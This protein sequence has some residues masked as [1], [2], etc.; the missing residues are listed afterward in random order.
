MGVLLLLGASPAWAVDLLNATLL[1]P[2]TTRTLILPPAADNAN[3]IPLGTAVDPATGEIVEGLAIIHYKKAPTHR[4][5]HG[6][7]G[8]TACYTYLSN[9]AKWKNVEPWVVN[10]ANLDDLSSTAVFDLLTS[11]IAKWED[12]TDGNV[13]N[14]LGVDVLGTGATSS[15]PLVADTTSP[16]NQNEVYFADIANS[17]TIAVTIVWGIF[18]GPTFNRKLVEWDQ[19]YD[20]VTFDWSAQSSG[21]LGKMDLDNIITHELGH[22]FGMGDLYNSCVDETMYGFSATAETNKRDLNTGDITGINKLY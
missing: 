2:G 4:P 8:T 19:I 3:V 1:T 15:A 17:N 11:G 16:D 13:G 20:D 22:S 5:G 7:G 14:T 12:A 9:G 10:P 6:S 18:S 21:V